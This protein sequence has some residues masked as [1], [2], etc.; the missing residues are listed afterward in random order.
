MS[1]S[2][3]DQSAQV[4]A[5]LVTRFDQDWLLKDDNLEKLWARV[6]KMLGDIVR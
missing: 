6:V 5:A 1:P 3:R 2:A 4:F